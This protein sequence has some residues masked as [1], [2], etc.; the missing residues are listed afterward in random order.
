MEQQVDKRGFSGP[1]VFGI[2]V[3]VMVVAV[4]GTIFAARAWFFPRPFK[5]VVLS[6]QEEKRLERKLEQFERWGDK[7]LPT[8]KALASQPQKNDRLP[9]GRLKPEAYSEKGASRGVIPA[10]LGARDTLRLEA[11]M[12]LYGNDID[13]LGFRVSDAPGLD[14]TERDQAQL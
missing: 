8:T 10:G 6:Q 2:A 3:L 5:P 13:E 7:P 4:V 1:Q 9:D 11:G 14:P 12:A